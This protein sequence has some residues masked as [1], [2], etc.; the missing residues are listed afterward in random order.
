MTEREYCKRNLDTVGCK[1]APPSHCDQIR[2]ASAETITCNVGVALYVAEGDCC[3][4]CH[5]EPQIGDPDPLPFPTADDKCNPRTDKEHIRYTDFCGGRITEVV[6]WCTCEATVDTTG[7]GDG[8]WS[9]VANMII[10]PDCTLEPGA[11][12]RWFSGDGDGSM[13]D[14]AKWCP[15]EHGCLPTDEMSTGADIIHTCQPEPPQCC[16]ALVASCLA[17]AA[18]VTEAEYCEQNPGTVGCKP[19]PPQCCKAMTASCLACAA[20][21]TE[22]EYCERNPGTV[23]C[24]P[25]Q[26][27][28]FDDQKRACKREE[29]C[30]W[31]AQKS[32][33]KVCVGKDVSNQ[34]VCG[35][36]SSKSSC[37][38]NRSC[39]WRKPMLGSCTQR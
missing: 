38:T 34:A 7:S 4:A 23:G 16:K 33:G 24:K 11:P 18:G 20:G 1:P 3:A 2:C 14:E 26:C 17:C 37:K 10:E 30:K 22:A 13:V 6:E 12:C 8:R 31:K 27:E 35:T 29:R 9:C 28:E 39:K 25:P 5:E 36:L 19:K 21:V 15:A 32:T